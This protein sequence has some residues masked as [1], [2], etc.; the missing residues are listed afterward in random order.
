MG[1]LKDL[2]RRELRRLGLAL[3]IGMAVGRSE[4]YLGNSVVLGSGDPQRGEGG[5]GA[6]TATTA[7]VLLPSAHGCDTILISVGEYGDLT[8]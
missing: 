8:W 1:Y 7:S 2:R 6:L 3:G 5:P 4:P